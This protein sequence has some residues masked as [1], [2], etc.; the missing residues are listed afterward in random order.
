MFTGKGD[1]KP[2]AAT[3]FLPSTDA[4][5]AHSCVFARVGGDRQPDNSPGAENR[6][7]ARHDA[8]RPIFREL[9]MGI[10]KADR[11]RRRHRFPV[12]KEGRD[13]VGRRSGRRHPTEGK[14]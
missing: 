9:T 5:R 3:I 10:E 11:I 14:H 4:W 6:R 8:S 1:G 12:I 2:T 7:R 13:A